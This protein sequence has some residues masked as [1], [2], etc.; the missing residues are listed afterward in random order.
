M[1]KSL[2]QDLRTS[3]FVRA[4]N[5][6]M[7]EAHGMVPSTRTMRCLGGQGKE[8]PASPQRVAGRA[9]FRWMG[10]SSKWFITV[11]APIVLHIYV[12]LHIYTYMYVF[13][14]IYICICIYLVICVYIY[15]CMYI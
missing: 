4:P 11:R 10:L 2:F 12:C 9:G 7:L 6:D 13:I 14:Y 3:I 1:Q 15:I 8:G 5:S